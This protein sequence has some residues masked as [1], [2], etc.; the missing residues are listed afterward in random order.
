MPRQANFN[1]D[2]CANMKGFGLHAAV[3]CAADERKALEQLCLFIT[4]PARGRARQRVARCCKR[5]QRHQ[6][7][8]VPAARRCGDRLAWSWPARMGKQRMPTAL[9]RGIC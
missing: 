1:Q 5:P 7:L 4:H 6:D 2:L 8:A 9:S 3:R